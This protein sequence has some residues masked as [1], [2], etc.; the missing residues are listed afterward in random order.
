MPTST[1]EIFIEDEEKKEAVELEEQALK[2]FGGS[3]TTFFPGIPFVSKDAKYLRLLGEFAQHS[4]DH[5]THFEERVGGE[6]A[7]GRLVITNFRIIFHSQNRSTYLILVV[8][9][10]I[11]DPRRYK[12][13]LSDDIDIPLCTID[14]IKPLQFSGGNQTT[15]GIDLT[16]KDICSSPSFSFFFEKY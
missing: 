1:L 2:A 8:Y 7:S 16:C 5:V 12:D 3:S 15:T 14:K 13:Q 6:C 4:R 9:F 10:S 11:I